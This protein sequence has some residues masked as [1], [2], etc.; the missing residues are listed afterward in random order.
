MAGAVFAER[1][2]GWHF[3]ATDRAAYQA[4]IDRQVA[5]S[6]Q[7][8]AYLHSTA[9][10]VSQSFGLYWQRIDASRYRG[11]RVRVSAFLKTREVRGWAG[12]WMRVD[13]KVGPSLEFE[14]M[15]RRPILGDTD[16]KPY[17]IELEVAQEAEEIH[18]GCLLVGQ[19]EVWF[20]DVQLQAVGAFQPGE[21]QMRRARHLPMEP[22]DPGF[23][24][25]RE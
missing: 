16:W 12:M 7:S 4:Q 3:Y 24:S 20:D 1:A 19:G 14:N 6:G 10:A 18:F 5:H 11:Q 15:Q 8:S 2:S 25:E 13:P 22:V 21:R 17:Q 9:A 23:E